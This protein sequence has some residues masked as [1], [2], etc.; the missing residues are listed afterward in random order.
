M[1][2]RWDSVESTSLL[3]SPPSS[4]PSFPVK[5]LNSPGV[6]QI[7]ITDNY[8]WKIIQVRKLE[9]FSRRNIKIQPYHK[10]VSYVF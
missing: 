3:T 9:I 10:A 5:T 2:E 8:H 6:V 7:N 4:N 1:L